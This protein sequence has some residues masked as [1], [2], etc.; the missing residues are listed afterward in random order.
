VLDGENKVDAPAQAFGLSELYAR[1]T[2]EVWAELG[3]RRDVVLA[4]RELQR[5]Y[6]NRVA[7]M[8]LRP[9]PQSRADARSLVRREAGILVTRLRAA[10]TRRGLSPLAQ[11]HLSDSA[12]T[13]Q[14]ALDASLQRTGV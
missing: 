11:A 3:S 13:L 5:E 1:L 7:A 14:R 4:R 12:Q 8:L 2:R 9:S 6:V 10:S